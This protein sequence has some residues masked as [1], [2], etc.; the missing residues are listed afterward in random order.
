ME[1]QQISAGSPYN[2]MDDDDNP[3]KKNGAPSGNQNNKGDVS[4]QI[5]DAHGSRVK[6]YGIYIDQ[7]V[8]KIKV[9]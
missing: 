4:Q 2:N 8:E 6:K 7:L 3:N 5:M 1:M 9:I